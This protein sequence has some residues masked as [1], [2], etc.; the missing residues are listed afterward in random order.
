MTTEEPVRPLGV[1]DH[2][3]EIPEQIILKKE[4]I[5]K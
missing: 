4:C 5:K 3:K 2:P 1:L